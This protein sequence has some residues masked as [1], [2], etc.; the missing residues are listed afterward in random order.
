[1]A[2]RHAQSLW[3]QI[4]VS[5]VAICDEFVTRACG[6]L[7][8]ERAPLVR[9]GHRQLDETLERPKPRGRRPSTAALTI[10]GARKAS[11]KVIRIE[12]SVLPSREAIDSK[13]RPGS[14]RS[15]SSQRFR[16]PPF[17]AFGEERCASGS[18]T[19]PCRTLH[20][21]SQPCLDVA[22]GLARWHGARVRRQQAKSRV[23][24]LVPWATVQPDHL[25][26][27]LRGGK[28]N[29]RRSGR[30]WRYR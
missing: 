10:S 15:T 26:G 7:E 9:P 3:P 1:L 24:F 22:P 28:G 12:R 21:E 20:L 18:V 25:C 30:L 23:E 17:S 11:D 8:S 4:C 27:A 29:C 14:E 16:V 2:A 5:R 13:A 19:A 6:R